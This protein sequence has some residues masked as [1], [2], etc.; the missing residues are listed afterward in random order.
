[1]PNNNL[2][3][4]DN[5]LQLWNERSKPTV[6]LADI[7]GRSNGGI[8]PRI[9]HLKNPDHKAYQRL[10]GTTSMNPA[11]ISSLPQQQQQHQ[12]SVTSINRVPVATANNNHKTTHDGDDDENNIVLNPEQNAALHLVLTGKNVYL[13]GAA[14]VGKTFLLR[15]IVSELT[16]K[17]NIG[18]GVAVTA[19]TGIAAS[20]LPSSAT[21]LHSF[22][23]IGLGGRDVPKLIQ[24]VM[25]NSAAYN[26]WRMTRTLVIDEIS[27]IDGVLF[28]TLD[29]IGKTIR[30][31]Q[32]QPFGG[33]QLVLCG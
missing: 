23:G 13:T 24:K 1:M 14:G 29:I 31:N 30:G 21:T 28:Q 7:F 25:N 18:S 19:S 16:K 9:K 6:E 26:R 2:W 3:T 10:F 22:A 4:R 5:D 17:Y 12:T 33:L 15:R 8:R 32:T 11:V 20:H 27:M